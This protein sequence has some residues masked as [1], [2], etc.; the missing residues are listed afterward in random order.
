MIVGII[1]FI[2]LVICGFCWFNLLGKLGVFDDC[3]K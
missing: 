3:E 1:G 2:F